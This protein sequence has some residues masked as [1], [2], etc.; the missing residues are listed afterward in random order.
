MESQQLRVDRC[1]AC[2]EFLNEGNSRKQFHNSACRSRYWRAK[3]LIVEHSQTCQRY[4]ADMGAFA[5]DAQI[6]EQVQREFIDIL[7]TIC[8]SLPAPVLNRIMEEIGR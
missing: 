5:L 8:N 7:K 2:G 1:P 4:I 3:R 6:G